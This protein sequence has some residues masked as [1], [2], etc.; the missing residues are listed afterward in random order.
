MQAR[1][2]DC[3]QR[4]DEVL[5]HLEHHADAK[6]VQRFVNFSTL[7]VLEYLRQEAAQP[8]DHHQRVLPGDSGSPDGLAL[9]LSSIAGSEMEKGQAQRGKIRFPKMFLL[10]SRACTLVEQAMP[11]CNVML[12]LNQHCVVSCSL[13]AADDNVMRPY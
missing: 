9:L 10:Y 1:K 3:C 11:S 13:S 2:W 7:D 8:N 4:M 5:H 6:K 12:K